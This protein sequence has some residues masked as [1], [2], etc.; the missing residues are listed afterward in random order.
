MEMEIYN[1]HHMPKNTK[2]GKMEIN[3]F[4]DIYQNTI[5][6]NY[7]FPQHMPKHNI[8]KNGKLL[9]FIFYQLMEK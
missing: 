7:K 3:N 6:G 5:Y 9:I 1:F 4:H 2:Y 8:W